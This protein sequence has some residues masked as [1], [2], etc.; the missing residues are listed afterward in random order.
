MKTGVITDGISRDLDHALSVMSEFGLEFAEI[1]FV[2]NREIGDHTKEEN[3]LIK[4]LLA[5]HGKRVSCLSRHLFAPL[6]SANRPGDSLHNSQME[7]LRRVIGLAQSLGS[8]LVRVMSPKKEMI[9][10]GEGGA[11]VWNV[12]GGAWDSAL[13]LMA[14]AADLA[15]R[16]NMT[17]VM[18]TGNGIIV[19]SNYAARRMIDDLDA[20]D[21]LKTLWD[22]ANCCW[23]H[24]LAW[25]DA[26]EE[27]RNGYLGHIHIKDV[28]VDT[29]RSH[30][31]VREYG[32]GQLALLFPKI[33]AALA[34]D[35]YGGVVSFESVYHPG[36]GSFEDGFR[37]CIA[38]FLGDFGPRGMGTSQ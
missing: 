3:H 30:L 21:C 20:K 11:E 17:L 19:N 38:G 2:W 37:A 15:R 23:C 14:P 31:A 36:N 18:E 32:Q 24:E 25:P 16:E 1:Q 9:L 26:Y 4:E 22:P 8:P 7:A 13:E 6:T 10:W 12:A 29:P 27:V 34:G 5:K 33:A 28:Q 35:G